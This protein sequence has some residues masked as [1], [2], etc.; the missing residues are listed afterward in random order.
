MKLSLSAAVL[1][2]VI[3][4]GFGWH[5]HQQLIHSR[6]R[7][8]TLLVEAASFGISLDSS[9]SNGVA[10]VLHSH[11]DRTIRPKLTPAECIAFV[12]EM[13]EAEKKRGDQP[14]EALQRRHMEFMD[15]LA[16][17]SATELQ[18]LLTEIQATPDLDDES[19]QGLVFLATRALINDHPQTALSVLLESPDLFKE[20][21]WRKNI[22]S[23]AIQR[24]ANDNPMAAVEWIRN[25][26]E[27]FPDLV[28]DDAKEN[29]LSSISLQNPKLAF[30][31]IGEFGFK[32]SGSVV[33]EIARAARTPE[34]RTTTLVALRARLATLE[35]KRASE[36]TK[37]AM[38]SFGQNAAREGFES[39]TSWV[40]N[41]HFSPEELTG[42]A[43]GLA[44]GVK[45]AETGRWIEWLDHTLPSGKS[46]ESIGL[47]MNRWTEKD[48]QAA[49][50]WL[51]QTADGPAK[52]AAIVSYAA[53]VAP[54]EPETA[55]EWAMTLP[56]GKKRD[57]ALK[58]IYRKWPKDDP[59]AK[60][61]AEAFAEKHG[62]KR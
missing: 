40:A 11:G 21:F 52:Q 43:S 51:T 27:K 55:A 59:A 24:L 44:Y 23:S 29:L 34:E 32:E 38:R 15:R 12:K 6:E 49:G 25:H 1:I 31:L 3:A 53:A 22:L 30:Q 2:L 19:R 62:I 17:L 41:S 35:S 47:M 14:N 46:E 39:V 28:D 54:Y 10:R 18:A 33:S 45:P 13:K 20:G 5:D 48:Y 4:T 26:G 57:E 60:E 36:E 56:A 42:F 50:T 9:K 8:A 61:A 16:A 37:Q 7:H 58:S